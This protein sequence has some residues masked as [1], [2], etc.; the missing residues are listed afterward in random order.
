VIQYQCYSLES[1][2]QFTGEYLRLRTVLAN[3]YTDEFLGDRIIGSERDFK[4]ASV[5]TT[6]DV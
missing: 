4:D 1:Y 3:T 6:L 2:L 5:L